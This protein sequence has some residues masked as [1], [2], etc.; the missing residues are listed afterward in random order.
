MNLLKA[1]TSRRR[2]LFVQS[3]LVFVL[4]LWPVA[5]ALAT[6]PNQAEANQIL[7]GEFARASLAAG[8]MATYA[9]T[10]PAAGTYT[11]VLTGATSP[12]DFQMSVTDADGAT[13]YD[14]VMQ[15]T[16]NL[17][18]VTGDHQFQFTAQADADLDFVIGIE[19]GSMSTDPD[20]PGEL[21]NGDTFLA[22]AVTDALY[23]TLTIE[24]LPNPQQMIVLVQGDAGDVYAVEVVGEGSA[25]YAVITTDESQVLQLVTTGAVYDLTITPVEGG[26]ALQVSVFLSGPVPLLEPG[27]AVDGELSDAE[28]TNTYQSVSYTHLDVYKRQRQSCPLPRSQ[29]NPANMPSSSLQLFQSQSRNDASLLT[30]LP[31]SL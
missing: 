7:L 22:K 6:P 21:I 15:D 20:A 13:L 16:T 30:C 9:L 25:D 8:E 1:T 5:P 4:S 3:M 12:S 2:K 10:I 27:V 14:D 23:A 19:G 29:A 17:E 11:V 24:P 26:D 28:D 31:S 18:L